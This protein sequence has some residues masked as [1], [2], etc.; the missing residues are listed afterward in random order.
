MIFSF[1]GVCCLQPVSKPGAYNVPGNP[2]QRANQQFNVAV[3]KGVKPGDNFPVLGGGFQLMV[4]CPE[5]VKEGDRIHV[6]APNSR[7]SESL[8]ARVPKGVEPGD[9]FP[10]KV[11]DKVIKVICPPGVG[12]GMD[13]HV[14]VS[15]PDPRDEGAPR[16]P[17]GETDFEVTVPRGVHPGQPFALLVNGQKVILEC[18]LRKGP[19]EKITFKM[20]VQVSDVDIR[21]VCLRYEKEGWSRCLTAELQ[22]VWTHQAATTGPAAATAKSVSEHS[23]LTR[24]RVKA[25]AFVR[26]LTRDPSNPYGF[27]LKLVPA[28]Q[29]TASTIVNGRTLA[30][31]LAKRVRDP[32]QTKEAWF[33]GEIQKLQVPWEEGH[34]RIVV[35]RTNLLED[36]MAAFESVRRENLRK[37]FRFEFAGEPGIDAGGVSRELYQLVSSELFH[38]DR[39]LFQAS[40]INQSCCQVNP[41]SGLLNKDHLRY[42]HFCGRLFAKALFDRQ[43]VNAHFVQSLYK[44]LL[45]WPVVMDDLEALDNDVHSNLL[46]LLDL[47][48]VSMLELDFTCSVSVQGKAVEEELKPGGASSTVTNETLEEYLSLQCTHRLLTR[49]KDQ[50]NALVTGFYDVIDAPLLT[51]FDFQVTTLFILSTFHVVQLDFQSNSYVDR[52][53]RFTGA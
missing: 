14:L 3:P 1:V 37:T 2:S 31:E 27:N 6:A 22:F 33:R 48:D 50:V 42:F 51:V 43:I 40:A 17:F 29:A 35:R 25:L 5:G 19:G 20:P 15:K 32:F 11:R 21:A 39:G 38:P 53:H 23:P 52:C 24:E 36:A 9:A 28:L 26:Q 4:R 30:F 18:P 10:V 8:L 12:E 46:K 41:A 16:A 47:D 49:V 45:G 34:V 44:H 7:S 13:I